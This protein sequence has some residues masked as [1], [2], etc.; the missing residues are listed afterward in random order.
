MK[1]YSDEFS[2]HYAFEIFKEQMLCMLQYIFNF[3][4]L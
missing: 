3:N 4:K 1:L 2:W